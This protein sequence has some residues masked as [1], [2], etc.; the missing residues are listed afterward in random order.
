[1]RKLFVVLS[2][3]MVASMLLSACGTAATT[4][5]PVEPA[6]VAPAPAATE[7]PPAAT[8]VPVA[9]GPKSKDPTTLTLADSDVSIDTL[10]PALAYDTA[11]GEIIQNTYDTLI[12][13]D[14][15]KL[16]T[17]VPLLAD[18]WTV[19]ADGK[20]YTF[21]IHPGVKFHNGD[22]LTATDV[23]YS[24][25]RGLLQAGSASPQWLLSEPFFGVGNQDVTTVI[26]PSGALQDDRAGLAKA[27]PA[28]VK[29]ACTTVQAAIVAD[30][31]AMT[32]T[33]TL[34]TPWGPFLATVAQSWGSIMDKKWVAANK[35]WDGS[36]D[37]W[38]TFYGV[39]SADDPFSA[40]ENGTGPFVLTSLKQGEVYTLDSF[41]G[42]FKG[43]AKLKH[44]VA[45]AVPEWGT[46]F[47]MMQ[48]GD[49]DMA[50]VPAANRS[51]WMPWSVRSAYTMSTRV[52]TIPAPQQ[53]RPSLSAFSLA[54]RPFR[55]M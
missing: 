2:F 42:Y 10:D 40:I 41:P 9:T 51:R 19:S 47:A 3:V 22:V 18:K 37:T 17:F 35:G 48:A 45:K 14:G 8:A 12:F 39:A 13:Y 43:E 49:A 32:V 5:A 23:A 11:S 30:D 24:F 44:I 31:A 20:T 53:I 21:N 36:C 33:M 55:R 34:A 6:T 16:D 46:R 25:Q 15:S 7:V 27:D 1:M 52:L 29:A 38:Q 26:D 28:K 50:T 4:A 54:C